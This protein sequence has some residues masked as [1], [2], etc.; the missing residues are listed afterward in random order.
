MPSQRDL[1][2]MRHAP[3]IGARWWRIAF[4]REDTVLSDTY[5]LWWKGQGYFTM[6]DE[7]EFDVSHFTAQGMDNE[8]DGSSRPYYMEVHDPR[9]EEMIRDSD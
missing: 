5:W 2:A 6:M 9:P 1:E 8:L 4:P 7:W 3:L